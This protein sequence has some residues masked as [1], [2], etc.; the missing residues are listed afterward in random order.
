[1]VSRSD[2]LPASKPVQRRYTA[3]KSRGVRGFGY[4]AVE[5]GKIKRVVRST[6]EAGI[7]RE[8]KQETAS[9]ILF[10]HRLP[11]STPNVEDS[12]HPIVIKNKLL[13]YMRSSIRFS[14]ELFYTKTRFFVTL[15]MLL[16]TT[17]RVFGGV[18]IRTI[19]LNKKVF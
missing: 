6:T 13:K 15:C 14:H 11:T 1:M 10:H 19:I 2:G 17:K 8:L 5:N 16:R 9:E 18:N 7:E 4:I 12:T 3:Q